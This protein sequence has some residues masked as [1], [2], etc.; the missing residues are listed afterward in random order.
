MIPQQEMEAFFYEE[1]PLTTGFPIING[2]IQHQRGEYETFQDW[3]EALTR[4]INADLYGFMV[5]ATY[6]TPPQ[7]YK[8]YV[9]KY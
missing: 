5:E 3:Q 7:K 9:P 1:I 2:F 8:T 6:H 4:Y